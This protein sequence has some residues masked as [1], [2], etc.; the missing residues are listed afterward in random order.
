MRAHKYGAK[1][2]E[3]DGH[4]FP[5]QKEGRRYQ[6]LQLLARAGAIANLELQPRFPLVVNGAKICEYR[7]DF[8]YFDHAKCATVIED[9][10]GFK[11]PDY[12]IKKKLVK[13]IYS[14]SILE[15]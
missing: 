4:R 2:C 7:A 11:T 1:A 13:A 8:Q 3:I 15:T 14:I 9:C 5:S 12:R 10:K 6:E